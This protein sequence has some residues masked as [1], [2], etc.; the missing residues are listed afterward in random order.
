MPPRRPIAPIAA[1]ELTVTSAAADI[2]AK[3]APDSLASGYGSGLATQAV[4]PSTTPL[5]VVFEGSTVSVQD[6][7]GDLRLG[8]LF[9]VGPTRST[10]LSRH[11]RSQAPR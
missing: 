4:S 3:V 6:A 8:Q 2:G 9:Y 10:L 7:S 5:P 11:P 1:T